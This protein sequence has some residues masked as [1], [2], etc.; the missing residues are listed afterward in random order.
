MT[1]ST[2]AQL[3]PIFTA[4]VLARIYLPQDYGLFGI[5]LSTAVIF[6]IFSNLQFSSGI[7]VARTDEESHDLVNISVVLSFLV[8]VVSLVILLIFGK[9]IAAL[10]DSPDSAIVLLFCPFVIFLQSINAIVSALAV[11]KKLFKAIAVNRV[12][13]AVLTATVSITLGLMTRN[14]LWLIAGYIAG[15]LYGSVFLTH[16]IRKAVGHRIFNIHLD[17]NKLRATFKKHLNYPKYFLPSEFI[18]NG[19]NQL[20]VFLL[21]SLSSLSAVG[22]YNMSLRILGLPISFVS[23]SISEVFR[24]RATEDYH[25]RGT[26]RPI[27]LKTLITLFLLSLIPFIVII[28]WGSD[29]FAWALGEKWRNAGIYTEALGLMYFFRF[30]V[31]PLSYIY[32]VAGNLRGD[33]LNHIYFFISSLLILYL[34]IPVSVWTAFLVYSIN[35][36]IIYLHVLFKSYKLSVNNEFRPAVV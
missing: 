32:V 24:Q 1:G 36:S 12:V 15:Q 17:G 14:Y 23:S 11:R 16:S 5:F 13:S 18:N 30:I 25:E 31:G 22:Y 21:S 20:P 35:Y 27:F 7:I 33:L 26:C 28:F 29:L 34:L 2:I 19:I 8:S 3:L 9:R 4:P 6:G 10:V